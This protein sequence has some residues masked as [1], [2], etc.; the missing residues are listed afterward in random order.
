VFFDKAK[1]F[2][3][4]KKSNMGDYME[5][6]W[7]GIFIPGR[8]EG[9]KVID[10][11]KIGF[12]IC[13]DHNFGILADHMGG[14]AGKSLDLHVLCSAEVPNEQSKCMAKPGGYLVHAS[15]GSGGQEHTAVYKQGKGASWEEVKSQTT[16]SEGI[17]GQLR[18][19]LIDLPN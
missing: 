2:S 17:T 19:F 15:T 10:N 6:E 13:F 4:G 12:E 5:D 7:K 11:L 9:I 3:Y 1:V 8:K 18:L 16:F 14:S